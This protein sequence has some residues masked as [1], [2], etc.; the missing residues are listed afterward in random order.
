MTHYHRFTLSERYFMGC[1][2]W[3]I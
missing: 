1:K 3:I 2:C